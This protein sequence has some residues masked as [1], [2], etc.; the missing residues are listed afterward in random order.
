LTVLITGCSSTSLIYNNA[1][2]LVRGK[3]DDYFPLS[4][5]QQKQLKRD[6]NAF[7]QWH[8][9]QELAE[10][11]KVLIQF[12]QQFSDGLSMQEIEFILDKLAAARIRFAKASIQSASL[13]LSTVSTEQVDYFDQDFH[14][15][16]A[17]EAERLNLSRQ[18]FNDQN[19]DD[20]VDKLEYWLGS[21]ND[22]Q[23]AQLRAISD[24]RPNNHQYWFAQREIKHNRL[25]KLLRLKSDREDFEQYLHNRFV[26]RNRG[27]E[28]SREIRLQGMTYWRHAMLDI[29]KIITPQ[30]RKTMISKLDEYA[31]DFEALSKQSIK[32]PDSI[33]EK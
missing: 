24:S 26:V 16:Q 8:R 27:D 33:T 10:Y 11:S 21:F 3:I 17:E 19:Y 25:S 15:D 23:L 14:K 18:K 6:I 29:D 5:S 32:R 1:D 22:D 12:S 20:L 2:W 13:F 31:S 7:F 28:K 4:G 9:H 30:Q